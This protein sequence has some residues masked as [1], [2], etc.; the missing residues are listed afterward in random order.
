MTEGMHSNVKE[1]IK[2]L[3]ELGLPKGQQNERSALCLLSLM[4]ITQ[5]K[6][7]SEA[8]SPLI[9][10]TP[11]MEFCRINYGKEYAP[12]SRETFRRFT[13]HQFVDA[14]I[15]LYNPDKPTR[16]V[17]SPKAVYQIEAETLELIKCY[18]TE[19]W[20]ELLAR[21]LSNRQTLVERYAKERQQNK[22]PVQIAE[23][24]EIYITPGEHSELIKAII[25]EFAPRY[26]PGG[27]LIY[28]GDTGEKMGYF[29]EE[30]L[31]QLGV[32]IDSH[33][34]MPDVVIYFP[35]KKWLLLIESVTSHGPVDHKRH[36]E[37]AKLFNGST[38][39]IVYVTAFPNRSLMARYLNNISWET[40]VWVA[41]APSHLI[42]FNG[43]RFLG[44]YE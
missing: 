9:G 28:A 7:W 37:L 5:D 1:A 8:E 26:V 3:K 41:D 11:M 23:G 36:E 22:I 31:R 32:V 25:E 34:K 16:P 38:A 29:D 24:K 4:N 20:S 44:P 15:A 35:E 14:G 6:T 40:E 42:H 17:N 30:L 33:G 39:G 19:E 10:I 12:N 13:M 21:Y 2:I 18:N 27:R 43:V